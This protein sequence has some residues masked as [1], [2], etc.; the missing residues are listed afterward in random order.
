MLVQSHDEP[1]KTPMSGNGCVSEL[2][3][4]FHTDPVSNHVSDLSRF[5]FIFGMRWLLLS[6]QANV[7]AYGILY[8]ELRKVVISTFRNSSIFLSG[9]AVFHS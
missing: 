6:T 1:V 2:F 7:L 5:S 3:E 9:K 4:L 8:L